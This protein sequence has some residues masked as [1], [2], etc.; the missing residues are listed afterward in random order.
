MLIRLWNLNYTT[1]CTRELKAIADPNPSYRCRIFSDVLQ[2]PRCIMTSKPCKCQPFCKIWYPILG[3]AELRAILSKVERNPSRMSK[4]LLSDRSVII[5]REGT[6]SNLSDPRPL[7]PHPL[8][9]RLQHV[10]RPRRKF[11]A[12]ASW[13]LYNH[14]SILNLQIHSGHLEIQNK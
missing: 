6:P 11:A 4:I 14:P 10:T 2:R 12:Q 5:E 13:C 9:L 3:Q 1:M 8:S 7:C